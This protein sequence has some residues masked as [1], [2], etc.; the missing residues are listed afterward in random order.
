MA[1]F[2]NP[3]PNA[4]RVGIY[5]GVWCHSDRTELQFSCRIYNRTTGMQDEDFFETA[6]EA[7]KCWNEKVLDFFNSEHNKEK[8]C[9]LRLNNVDNLF[10]NV[11]G[12]VF[13]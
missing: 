4:V 7:A 6:E 5:Y 13:G 8:D 2:S 9:R 12:A 10:A 1:E 11:E 3:N